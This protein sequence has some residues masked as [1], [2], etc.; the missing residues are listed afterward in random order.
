VTVFFITGTDTGIGKTIV[1]AAIAAVFQTRARSIAVVKPAQTGLGPDEPGDADEV[2][3]L[4]GPLDVAE[5]VRLADPYAPDRAA[6]LAGR[7]LP[8]LG[9]QRDLVLGAAASHDIVLVEGSGG[10]AVN[11]GIAFTLL[12]IAAQVR[13]AGTDLAW[14]VV[15][16]TRLGTLNHSTLTVQAIQQR[17]FTVHGL[18]IG[19]WPDDPGPS[20]HYNRIDLARYTGVRVVGAVPCG[21]SGLEPQEFRAQAPSWLPYL[22]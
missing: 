19:C 10:V 6:T 1:T 8:S 22:G 13:N 12:D 3:R 4:A 20:D 17:G 21:A 11:L 5:R 7:T 14:F 2:R 15:C 16:G 9:E 18:V